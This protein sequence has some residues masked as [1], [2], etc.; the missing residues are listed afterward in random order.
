[1]DLFRRD[2]VKEDL[3]NRRKEQFDTETVEAF[4][5]IEYVFSLKGSLRILITLNEVP[6][7]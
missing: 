7:L 6:D 2:W 5:I 4:D 1:M 3:E